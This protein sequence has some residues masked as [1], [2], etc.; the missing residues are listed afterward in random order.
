MG[1]VESKDSRGK[2][3]G[4]TNDPRGRHQPPG[5]TRQNTKVL[6]HPNGRSNSEYKSRGGR[7]D[8]TGQDPVYRQGRPQSSS[9][10]NPRKDLKFPSAPG[11]Q[12]MYPPPGFV[13]SQQPG[14]HTL[15]RTK[16]VGQDGYD[17][18]SRARRGQNSSYES[19]KNNQEKLISSSTL[20]KSQ[21][22][23]N[24][25]HSG[26]RWSQSMD[27]RRKDGD[28]SSSSNNVNRPSSRHDQSRSPVNNN[29]SAKTVATPSKEA[30]GGDQNNT[31]QRNSFD[32]SSQ[33]RRSKRKRKKDSTVGTGEKPNLVART[34]GANSTDHINSSYAMN[35]MSSSNFKMAD[36]APNDSYNPDASYSDL[37]IVSKSSNNNNT[38][39][40]SNS[41]TGFTTQ[42]ATSGSP[43]GTTNGDGNV[44]QHSSKS[45]PRPATDPKYGN[46]I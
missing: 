10:F 16:V 17:T 6:K 32:R 18:T 1:C 38:K 15:S 19:A 11:V 44:S 42:N 26:D 2:G 20:P 24:G 36:G 23:N 5:A 28:R 40:G 33:Y 43:N 7:Y 34:N 14:Q 9:E 39:T 41:K 8:D 31:M 27:R 3:G 46:L 21:T 37:A 35:T 45:P 30:N 22:A 4:R 13:S 25:I 29:S 12:P